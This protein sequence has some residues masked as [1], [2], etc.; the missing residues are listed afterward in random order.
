MQNARKH[1]PQATWAMT[2]ARKREEKGSN[3]PWSQR[4]A[5]VPEMVR[6]TQLEHG[7]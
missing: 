4:E 1:L 2:H 3:L 7:R 5:N 6:P